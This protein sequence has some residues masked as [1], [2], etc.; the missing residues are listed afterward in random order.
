MLRVENPLQEAHIRCDLASVPNHAPQTLQSQI[1]TLNT[2]PET[3]YPEA[4][5]MY[6]IYGMALPLASVP[7]HTPLLPMNT[8]SEL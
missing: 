8:P 4:E 1:I 3:K 6:R 5:T 2:I 7:D